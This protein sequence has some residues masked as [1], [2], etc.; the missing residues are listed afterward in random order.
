MS[1]IAFES[2]A[3]FLNR[4]SR[5]LISFKICCVEFKNVANRQLC[6][7]CLFCKFSYTFYFQRLDPHNDNSAG[8]EEE[9]EG[10]VPK[11][12]DQV[13]SESVNNRRDYFSVEL[14][15][16]VVPLRV[17]PLVDRNEPV[18][19]KTAPLINDVGP[20]FRFVSSSRN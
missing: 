15:T 6:V 1:G 14:I 4:F 13:N 2:F 16:V 5:F 3:Q 9:G 10:A 19:R 11:V 7:I 17:S 20:R 18:L 8:K 12:L